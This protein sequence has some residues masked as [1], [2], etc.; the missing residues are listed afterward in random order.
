MWILT[1]RQTTTHFSNVRLG[2]KI[3]DLTGYQEALGSIYTH[4]LWHAITSFINLTLRF[5]GYKLPVSFLLLR[6][7]HITISLLPSLPF[8]PL[9]VNILSVSLM[10]TTFYFR[11][12]L[13]NTC[14]NYT[15][16]NCSQLVFSF[17]VCCFYFRQEI[18]EDLH[19]QKLVFSLTT[20]VGLTRDVASN[21]KLVLPGFH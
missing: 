12:G 14:L 20:P 1:I 4:T 2:T 13:I 11:H 7:H 18:E 21:Y 6:E 8:P 17:E 5:T 10:P 15:L 9:S 19:A 3:P 16:G